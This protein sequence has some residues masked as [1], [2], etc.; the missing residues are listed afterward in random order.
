MKN[1]RIRALVCFMTLVLLGGLLACSGVAS[2]ST[3]AQPEIS[4]SASSISFGN[5]VSSSSK[6]LTVSNTGTANLVISSLAMT[7][8]GAAQFAA[9]AGT[10]PVTVAPNASMAVTLTFTP[11]AP[12]DATATLTIADNASGSPHTVALSGMSLLRM[13]SAPGIAYPQWRTGRNYRH[14][15]D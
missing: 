4:L 8:A 12:G 3:G 15:R 11:S 6:T 1:Q 5:Q 13:P 2:H 7:G 14:G 10:L 9:A